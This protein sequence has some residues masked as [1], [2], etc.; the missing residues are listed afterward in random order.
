MLRSIKQAL[1]K[2]VGMLNAFIQVVKRR[3]HDSGRIFLL[4]IP[5]HGNLGDHLISI[6]EQEF[7]RDHFP[8][9]NVILVPSADLYY[10]MRVSLLDVQDKDILCVTG[11]GF[12][13]S[14]Y[15]EEQRFL[16]LVKRFPKNRIIFFPQTFYYEPTHRGNEMIKIAE[17][18]YSNHKS[19]YIMARDNNSYTLLTE[20][21]MRQARDRVFLVPDFA[22]YCHLPQSQNREGVKW[23]LRNDAEINQNN[24]PIINTLK[25]AINKLGLSE[26][27]T[28]TYVQ[29]PIPLSNEAME[30][31][32]MINIIAHS[33]LVI[34]DR[35]HG[36]IYSIITDTPVIALDNLSHK[37]SQVYNL[38]LKDIPFVK[39]VDEHSTNLE[40]LIQRLLT[41]DDYRFDNSKIKKMYQPIIDIM[42]E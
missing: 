4:N 35:L 33:Q 40:S 6:A 1:F 16:S 22:L 13:G 18:I 39:V 19:L 11:G 3:H 32:S 34:T 26:T 9:M 29:R 37:V 20:R 27:Y 38:W 25:K 14:L 10:S 2:P 42:N 8:N 15:S 24:A 21:L 23:C 12:M 31:Q 5:S 28:D 41:Q 36:M 7:L 17:G 30:V